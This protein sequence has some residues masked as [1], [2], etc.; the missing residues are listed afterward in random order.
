MIIM[1]SKGEIFTGPY[2]KNGL[3]PYGTLTSHIPG[4]V[5]LRELLRAQHHH[6]S[7]NEYEGY[8][9]ETKGYVLRTD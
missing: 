4:H 7:F 5:I 8:T 2:F 1:K 6:V 9:K 3:E